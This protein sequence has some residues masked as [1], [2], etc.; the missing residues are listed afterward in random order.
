M[1]NNNLIIFMPS[2][3]GGGVEKNLFLITNDFV[4]K[5]NCITVITA[6][7]N[8]HKFDGKIKIIKPKKNNYFLKFRYI[9]IILSVLFLIRELLRKK[10]TVVLSFQANIYA[11]ITC[12]LL[13]KKIIAR[14]NS[15]PTGW[16][17]GGF[18]SLFFKFILSLANTIIVNSREFHKELLSK[19]KIHSICILNPLDKKMIIQRS[20]K[21][22]KNPFKKKNS[23]KFI[24]IGRL[25]DQKDHLTL[26]KAFNHIKDS[27]NFELLIIGQ[28][29]N[30]PLI[31]EYININKLNKNIKVVGFK[32]NPYPYI[33][34]S[35]AL[36]LTS[37]YE[38]LPNVI[39]ES[40][41][42]KKL[43]ISSNCPTGPKEILT[44]GKGGLLF[45]T[46]SFKDLS[47]KIIFFSKYKKKCLLKVK[48]SQLTLGRYNQKLNL[49]KYSQ[50]VRATF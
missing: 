7:Q 21:N 39:L 1:I 3:E 27:L 38:G 18:K 26:L 22:I 12:R 31:Q 43:V 6:S 33:K 32:K 36:V 16:L 49:K 15:S 11:I 25:V 23:L 29:I 13:N 47:R 5:F 45:K 40:L 14:A 42:L 8:V 10:E 24:S 41:V 20:N 28:G 9:K 48:F 44:N 2:I 50:L 19:L 17:N 34:T 35:D 4:N 30:K 46:G 37:R